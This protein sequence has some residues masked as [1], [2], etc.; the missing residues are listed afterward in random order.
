MHDKR[1]GN[2]STRKGNVIAKE[3]RESDGVSF[4]GYYEAYILI[5]V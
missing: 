2:V 1:A 4:R 5:L 3:T